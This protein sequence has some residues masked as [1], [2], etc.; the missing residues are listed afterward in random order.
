M[1]YL[2]IA[3]IR[4]VGSPPSLDNAF[5]MFS[6]LLVEPVFGMPPFPP[7]EAASPTDC[8]PGMEM[9]CQRPGHDHYAQR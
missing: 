1:R 5:S 6:L 9:G 8:L 3:M 4:Q 7:I 2:M